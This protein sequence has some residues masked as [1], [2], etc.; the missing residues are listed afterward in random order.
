[1]RDHVAAALRR[2]EAVERIAETQP[3]AV[4]LR[5]ALAGVRAELEA[6]NAT[7]TPIAER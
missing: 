2:L 3:L 6:I 4:L 7:E 5:M 1:M